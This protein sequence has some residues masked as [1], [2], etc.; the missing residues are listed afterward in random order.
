MP[1]VASSFRPFHH[2]GSVSSQLRLGLGLSVGLA[3]FFFTPPYLHPI[4][5]WVTAWDG[6]A[7]A[8]LVV[9]WSSITTSDVS[10]IR[11]V[12]T[13][14]DPGRILSF[15]FVL[16]GAV[17]SLLAVA[18]LLRIMHASPG[19]VMRMQIA[20][21]VTAV[22]C[23][24]LLLHTIFTL[25]YAH[26]YYDPDVDG[27]EGGL[28]F[29]GAEKEPDYLDFAYFSFVIGMTAQ[30]ADISISGRTL[31]RMALLHG[32]LAYGFNTAIIALSIS[33]LASVL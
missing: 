33:S 32:I 11:S 29:P 20:S 3:A 15:S 7:F 19:H 1:R 2:L 17:A 23:A 31:R 9:I 27:S 28:E 26:L 13:A 21:S 5:R 24:W 22:V 14:E 10:R 16:V 8:T 18:V 25:R 6:F 4:T 30:T 12:A